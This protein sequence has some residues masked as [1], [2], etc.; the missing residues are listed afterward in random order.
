MCIY[1]YLIDFRFIYNFYINIQIGKLETGLY[2]KN[3]RTVT[4][5]NKSVTYAMVISTLTEKGI[6]QSKWSFCLHSTPIPIL[7][8]VLKQELSHSPEDQ[9]FRS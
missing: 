9:N 8:P 4:Q 6:P 3:P 2:N 5:I 1:K 7:C